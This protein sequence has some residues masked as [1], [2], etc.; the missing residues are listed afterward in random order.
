MMKQTQW[1]STRSQTCIVRS[2]GIIII[3]L[4]IVGTA[5]AEDLSPLFSAIP[6]S[7]DAPLTVSFI[8]QSSGS[9]DGWNW[10]FGDGRYSDDENPVHEYIIPGTY[11]PL[12]LV[13]NDTPQNNATISISDYIT[14]SDPLP[15]VA[16]FA[17][18][19]VSG[20]DPL[21]VSFL[22][23]STGA[24]LTYAWD[25]NGDG[26]TDSTDPNPVYI[27]TGGT[28]SISLTVTDWQKRT[29]STQKE[30]YISV[31][32][33]TI[34]AGFTIPVAEGEVPFPVS[35]VDQSRGPDDRT[36]L[37][38]FER[39]GEIYHTTTSPSPIL[40]L[41]EAGTWIVNQTVTSGS[42]NDHASMIIRAYDPLP[43]FA[44]FTAT[45]LFGPVP[46]IVSFIDQSDGYNISYTWDFGDGT[47]LGHDRNPMHTYTIPGSY[48]VRMIASNEHGI[49]V[50]EK[51]PGYIE[52]IASELA[53]GF[54]ASVYEGEAPLSVSLIDQSRGSQSRSYLWTFARDGVVQYTTT[55][56]SPILTLE[57]AGTWTVN[58]TV[59]DG[60]WSDSIEQEIVVRDPSPPVADYTATPR[61]GPAPLNVSFVDQSTGEELMYT[62]DFGDGSGLSHDKNPWHTY[63]TTGS[64]QVRLT[65]SNGNGIS[66]ADKGPG[67]ITVVPSQL[68]AGFTA[69]VYE[70]E[71]PLSVSLIDQ[72]LG[73][74]SRSWFWT[75]ARDGEI[76]YTSTSV[77]PIL[78]LEDA[79]IWTVNQT[80]SDGLWSDSL[81]R[82]IEV[83]DSSP[84]VANFTYYINEDGIDRTIQCTDTSLHI[85]TNWVWEFGDGTVSYEQNPLHT[86]GLYGTYTLSLTVSNPAGTDSIQKNIHLPS[87]ESP[88]TAGFNVKKSNFRTFIFSDHS[89][90]SILSYA[91]SFGDGQTESYSSPWCVTHSYA[92]MGYF[93]VTLQVTNGEKSDTYMQRIMVL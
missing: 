86:Y 35:I 87:P 2:V 17:A 62:W 32:T 50:A 38:T 89:T 72:S 43:P 70:G 42:L 45:P 26:T 78:T 56:V 41:E 49:S 34:T 68:T 24:D 48:T 19:P 71:A 92:H 33:R 79:G 31:A 21:T 76:Q 93:P 20:Y 91:L 3:I 12:L 5:G 90:G 27:Y 54:T 64:F 30:D 74:Q 65:I 10:T 73:S 6:V 63:E 75:F 88:V 13:W 16:D 66:V 29:N 52:V 58:Q 77:S 69:S 37:Y 44:A 8:D 14:V 85:P 46:F 36:Y 60:L 51:G 47:P 15:P 18:T 23:L 81:L 55:S 22:S 61:Y 1:S 57:E 84:P 53:A 59:S 4:S 25:L 40:I 82:E 11:S 80:V 9:I 39:D 28:Y 83:Y 67:Y 7:G